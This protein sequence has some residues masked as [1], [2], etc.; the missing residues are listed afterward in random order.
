MVQFDGYLEQSSLV[1]NVLFQNSE[2]N[3]VAISVNINGYSEGIIEFKPTSQ[4]EENETYSI[5]LKDGISA[6]D[7]YS[8]GKTETINFTTKTTT[9]VNDA[10]SPVSYNLISA[11]PNPF[12]PTTTIEYQLKQSSRVSIKIYDV[13]GNLVTTLI[14]KEV[15]A[16]VHKTSFNANNL[17]SGVYFSRIITN[18][19]T[20]TIKLL[21]TKEY[22]YKNIV[23]ILKA[24]HMI[25]FFI[26]NHFLLDKCFSV[27][28]VC[29]E[30]WNTIYE[31]YF[32]RTSR[33]YL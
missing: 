3:G 25:R 4:L 8:F 27:H 7:G 24:N 18:S 14:N 11:Y 16:G 28:Y 20:K 5:I 1:G 19:E 30:H 26:L 33:K 32:N 31:K 2:G 12:N 22:H 13:I 15:N 6:T 21:L 17:P 29:S 9:S 23:I 10:N